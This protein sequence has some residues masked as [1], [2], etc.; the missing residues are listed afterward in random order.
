[1]IRPSIPRK[2]GENVIIEIIRKN[3]PI[4]IYQLGK[5]LP[6][7]SYAGIFNYVKFLERK[8]KIKSKLILGKNNRAERI[9][10]VDEMKGGEDN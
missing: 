7:V 1:M 2:V 9:L 8:G 4:S 10:F 6:Y 5:L 3:Q